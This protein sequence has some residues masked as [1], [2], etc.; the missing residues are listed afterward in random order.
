MT[1]LESALRFFISHLDFSTDGSKVGKFS[2]FKTNQKHIEFSMCFWLVLKVA[3]FPTLEP[4][5]EKSRCD[6]KK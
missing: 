5:V 1:P 4:S 2:T 3:N 6:M